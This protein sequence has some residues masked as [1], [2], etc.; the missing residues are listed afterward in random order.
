MSQTNLIQ[1]F[2]EILNQNHDF[3]DTPKWD[4]SDFN[5]FLF[6]ND[7]TIEVQSKEIIC[8][9]KHIKTLSVK[10]YPEEWRLWRYNQIY[11]RYFN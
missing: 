1:L 5:N 9:K 8:D 11:W 4:G 10:E 2:Y 6:A 3:R 7:N